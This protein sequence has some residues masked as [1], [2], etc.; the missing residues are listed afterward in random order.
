MLILVFFVLT[1]I[2]FPL[3]TMA[4]SLPNPLSNVSNIV[5]LINAII[6]FL[7]T[8]ALAAAPVA[9]VVG[10]WYLLVSGGDPGKVTTGRNIIVIALIGVAIIVTANVLIS[11]IR[12]ILGI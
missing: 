11:I 5:D 10:A 2:V 4:V 8:V 12:N 1:I 6:S 7:Q 9:I 3:F